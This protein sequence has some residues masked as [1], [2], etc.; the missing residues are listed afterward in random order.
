MGRVMGR[1]MWGSHVVVFVSEL[2]GID[3]MVKSWELKLVD[4]EQ[5]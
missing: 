4:H 5:M 2:E 3:K 1:V